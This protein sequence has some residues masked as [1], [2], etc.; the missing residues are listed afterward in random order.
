MNNEDEC[1][2]ELAHLERALKH[3]PDAEVKNIERLDRLRAG[4]A[5]I[6]RASPGSGLGFGV[7]AE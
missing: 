3:R 1:L 5:G 7:Q 6:R 4:F 2:A